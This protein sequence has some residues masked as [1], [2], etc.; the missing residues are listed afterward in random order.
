[1]YKIEYS[2]LPMLL[3]ARDAVLISKTGRYALQAACYLADPELEGSAV[4][5]AEIAE[6]T[7]VPKNYLSKILHQ[8]ARQGVL[9]SERGPRGGYRLAGEPEEIKLVTVVEAVDPS[10]TQ[11]A[12]LLGRSVCSDRN[13]CNAHASWSALT[14][15]I[16]QFLGETSLADLVGEQA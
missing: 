3:G 9:V 14:G 10:V 16:R 7:G 13:P 11:P 15:E 4:Q 5:A 6:A 1:M 2:Q 12:C 8:L